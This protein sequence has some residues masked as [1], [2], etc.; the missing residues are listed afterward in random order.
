MLSLPILFNKLIKALNLPYITMAI[1][2]IT[3]YPRLEYDVAK[4]QKSS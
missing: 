1:E 3:K 4:L 2:P